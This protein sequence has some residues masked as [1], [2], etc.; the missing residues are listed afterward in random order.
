MAKKNSRA[1]ELESELNEDELLDF[2]AGPDLSV[3][4]S[5]ADQ[6]QSSP[7][8]ED[9]GDAGLDDEV[10]ENRLSGKQKLLV[11]LTVTVSF[12]VFTLFFFP[13]DE[14]IRY[15]LRGL[16]N[17][18]S[19]DFADLDL[20]IIGNDTIDG[21][22]AQLPQGVGGFSS[23]HIE[24]DLAWRDLLAYSPDGTV[25]FQTSEFHMQGFAFDAATAELVVKIKDASR[26]LATWNGRVQLRAGGVKFTNLPLESLPLP[27]NLQEL[28]VRRLELM[29]NFA[30]GN[31]DFQDSVLASDLFTIRLSGNGRLGRSLGATV[32]ET[33]LCVKPAPDLE[34]KN[35]ELFGVY[36][37][38][39]GAAGGELCA[40]VTGTIGQPQ[41]NVQRGLG[42]PDASS[43]AG[44]SGEAFPN[45]GPGS[46]TAPPDSRSDTAVEPEPEPEQPEN[47]DSGDGGQ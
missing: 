11:L 47:Y 32:L 40:D 45:A 9:E 30:N 42:F 14:L 13:L 22:S 38:G 46:Q 44:A 17:Q 5:A 7:E 36:I 28:N 43:T 1:P 33:K 16:E 18:V 20:N 19:I 35:P 12:F 27:I 29:M 39:G 26:P 2:E 34:T 10:E 41:V 15:Q 37:M 4:E 31:V 24:S 23:E 6:Q 21:F 8:S 25:Q 3:A